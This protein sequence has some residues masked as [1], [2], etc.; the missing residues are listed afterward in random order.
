MGPKD[1]HWEPLSMHLAWKNIPMAI[2]EGTLGTS[3]PPWPAKMIPNDVPKLTWWRFWSLR[4]FE[5][6]EFPMLTVGSPVEGVLQK[7]SWN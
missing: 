2:L 5:L 6:L 1:D 7:L 3:G 4:K